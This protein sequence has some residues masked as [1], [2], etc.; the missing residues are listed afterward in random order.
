MLFTSFCWI[1]VVLDRHQRQ[2]R[3]QGQGQAVGR[4]PGLFGPLSRSRRRPARLL[5]GDVEGPSDAL[6]VSMDDQISSSQPTHLVFS[7]HFTASVF[8]I[9]AAAGQPVPVDRGGQRSRQ[10]TLKQTGRSTVAHIYAPKKQ[11]KQDTTQ[12]N[13]NRKRRKR[14]REER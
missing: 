11:T 7:S 10:G 12:G 6:S 5:L 1:G 3:H 2:A 4:V 9:G 14:R 8:E 13:D